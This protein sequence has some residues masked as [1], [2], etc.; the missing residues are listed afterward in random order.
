MSRCLS[1][2]R[3]IADEI[4]V[5][6]DGSTDRTKEIAQKFGARFMEHTW[7]GFVGQK[8]FAISQAQYN[9][10]FSIDADEEISEPLREEIKAVKTTEPQA[11]GF[12]IS[13]VVFYK[14]KWIRFG[15]WYPDRL[16]RLFRK[17]KGRFAGGAVH[18]RLEIQGNCEKLSGELYHYTYKDRADHLRRIEKYSTLWAETARKEGKRACLATAWMRAAWKFFRGFFIKGGWKGKTLGFEIAWDN[19]YETLLKYKKLL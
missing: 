10:I 16:V 8:N 18:E 6:D 2:L 15:D 4:I 12:E 9:W 11:S 19:A 14:E 1:S 5:V 17:D 13:R 7:E 3:D